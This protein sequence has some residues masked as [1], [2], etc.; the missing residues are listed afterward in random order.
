MSN[1]RISRSQAAGTAGDGERCSVADAARRLGISRR[2]VEQR[3][4]AGTLATVQDG[5]RLLVVLPASAPLERAAGAPGP[6]EP[7]MGGPYAT[8]MLDAAK[9]RAAMGDPVNAPAD[10]PADP[11]ATEMLD[12]AKVRAAMGDPANA[13]ADAPADPYAT[14]MLDAAKVRAAMSERAVGAPA[15]AKPAEARVPAVPYAPAMS[16]PHAAAAPDAAA[17]LDPAGIAAADA[18]SPYATTQFDARSMRLP[19]EPATPTSPLAGLFGAPAGGRQWWFWL[20][21]ILIAL[22]VGLGILLLIDYLN[23]GDAI[24]LLTEPR[25]ATFQQAAPVPTLPPVPTPTLRAGRQ[26]PA[27]VVAAPTRQ[28]RPTATPRPRP[29]ATPTPLPKL[30]PIPRNIPTIDVLLKRIAAATG[31]LH[32]GAFDAT[33]DYGAGAQP[34]AR[35]TFDRGDT[36]HPIRFRVRGAYTNGQGETI[37]ERITIGGASWQ[38]SADGRWQ[39]ALAAPGLP[40]ELNPLLPMLDSADGLNLTPVAGGVLLRWYDP[41]RRADVTL[42]VDPASGVPRQLQSVTRRQGTTL[43][44]TYRRWNTPVT[45]QP[46]V[47]A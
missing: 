41:V 44:V 21:Q 27:L 26:S 34:L 19:G 23:D 42:L 8:E 29:A 43:V 10:A 33:I 6:G 24:P 9:V 22:V 35:L 39:A 47:A 16:K 3:I 36:K 32:T 28:P 38:R 14:E 25:G 18:A 30:A 4:R 20:S 13:P 37:V 1:N 5:R 15:P 40:S 7:G 12:A 46:P 11:Y 17:P 45:I 31:S 2:A